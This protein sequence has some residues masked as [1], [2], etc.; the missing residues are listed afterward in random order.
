MSRQATSAPSRARRSA[1]ARPMPRRRAAPVTSATLPAMPCSAMRG[2]LPPRRA[3]AGNRSASLRPWTGGRDPA[4]CYA[5]RMLA[6]PALLALAVLA[7]AASARPRLPAVVHR[8]G[9]DLRG[10]RRTEPRDLRVRPDP[11]QGGDRTRRDPHRQPHRRPRQAASFATHHLIVYA[12]HGPP[13]RRDAGVVKDDTAC[14]NFGRGRPSDL[15][16]VATSQ[17]STRAG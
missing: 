17:G 13:R 11:G 16:I 2:A 5:A 8:E 4:L 14:L 12:Y 7:A 3:G 10:A 15:S 1:V 6:R 9:A